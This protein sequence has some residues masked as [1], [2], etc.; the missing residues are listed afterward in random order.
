MVNVT[1]RAL[2]S[3][4]STGATTL[5]EAQGTFSGR[6]FAGPRTQGDP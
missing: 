6:L 4:L 3:V 1:G 5:T 2:S